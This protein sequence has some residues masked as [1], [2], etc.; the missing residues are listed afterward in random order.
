VPILGRRADLI[1][2]RDDALVAV[3]LKL[4]DW[5]EALRQAIAYQ[6]AAPGLGST[7]TRLP[8]LHVGDDIPGPDKRFG[9]DP[10]RA[11]SP[12]LTSGDLCPLLATPSARTA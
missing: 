4:R 2:T 5:R 10:N 8:G 11:V 12:Y 6:L 7:E 9:G 1:G 3:E